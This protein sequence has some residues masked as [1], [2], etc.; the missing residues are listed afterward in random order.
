MAFKWR[1]PWHDVF[2]NTFSEIFT[3]Q[4][5]YIESQLKAACLLVSEIDVLLWTLPVF[6]K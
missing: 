6:F 1:I 3:P 4:N 5:L 2:G